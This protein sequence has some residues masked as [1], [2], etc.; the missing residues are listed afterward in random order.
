MGQSLE[1]LAFPFHCTT[2]GV[3][4]EGEGVGVEDLLGVGV[5]GFGVGGWVGRG[6]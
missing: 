6:G 3:L 1:H 2:G 4:G 5:G